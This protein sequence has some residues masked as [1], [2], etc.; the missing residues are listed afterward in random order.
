M[1]VDLIRALRAHGI[2]VTTVDEQGMRHQADVAVLHLASE[3][4]RIVYT[5]NIGDFAA[6]H[7][8][9]LTSGQHHCGIIAVPQQRY[10]IGEQLRRLLRLL[11]ARATDD[12]RDSLEYLSSWS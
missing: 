11:E 8:Q 2:D 4:G 9:Y 5:Q 1:D 10:S 7:T 3:L 6:L 12:M